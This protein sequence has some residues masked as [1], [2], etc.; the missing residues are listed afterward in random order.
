MSAYFFLVSWQITSLF[1][2]NIME[3]NLIRVSLRQ[4][5]VYVPQS[6][7]QG[8]PKQLS[9]GTSVFAANLAK[10]GYGMSEQLLHAIDQAGD[11]Y[12]QGLMAIFR[13]VM[14]VDKNWTP[15][16]K[17]WLVPTGESIIDHIVTFFA[18]I[19]QTA[20]PRLQCG[21]IIPPG[22]F[23]LERY[24]GCP[25]CGTPFEFGKIEVMGQGKKL[26]VLDRWEDADVD[27]FL[28]SL[29]LSKTA[30]DATQIDS[31]QKLLTVRPLPSVAVGMK[32]TLMV[33]IDHLIKL[34][35]AD[36]AAQYF[37][38]PTDILRYLWY[39]HTG[40]LQI[41]EPKTIVLRKK[42]NAVHLFR[43]LDAS[44]Q[45]KLDA[46]AALKLK[47]GRRDSIRVAKWLNE[48]ALPPENMAEIMHPKRNIW[49]R[50]IRALRLAEY[51]RRPGFEN[52]ATLLDI[53]YNQKY[54]VWQGKV[55]QYRLRKDMA[56]TLALLQQR[57]GLFARSLFAT[58]LWFG[59]E[60]PLQAFAEVLDKV[61][62]RLVFTL[63]M[64]AA[65]YFDPASPRIV[66]PLGGTAKT[67]AKHPLL[68]RYSKEQRAAMVEGIENLSL[69]VMKKRF[70]AIPNSNKTMYI[71]PG[72]FKMPVAI[73]DRSESVQDMPVA[74]MGT[75]FL[76]EGSAV[77]LF[78]QWGV[79]LPAMHLDMDLSAA[80]VY[81][82]RTEDCAYFNLTPTG[83][84]HSGDIQQ[85]PEKIGTAEYVELNLDVLQQAQ[86]LYAVFACNA[87]TSGALSPNMSVG[88]MTCAS[89]MHVSNE[90]GVAYDP[91]TVQHQVRIQNSLSKGLCFGMLE[92]A[93]REIVWME[94]PF[95]GQTVRGMKKE[96][97]EAMLRKLDS[98]LSVGNLLKIKA[99][100]QGLRIVESG[101]ADEIYTMAWAMNAAA[102]TQLLTD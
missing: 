7:T 33:V 58:M 69:L 97:I 17:N 1:F 31:L 72:L 92:I 63:N 101:E 35:R 48:M 3:E 45:A 22:T 85:I 57:P 50:F 6:G 67:V 88:W 2:L 36:E 16:V 62:A 64:Y 49:V 60:G 13:E 18:N 84:L 28:T 89:P 65:E 102:V 79:G 4:M 29:L 93:T 80:I 5:A 59:P 10:L 37:K 86:A 25:F 42:M 98:K 32:E 66:K 9:E 30:L 90:T 20:G 47:Y 26:K 46:K 74:L 95:G 54:E 96:A 24:N 87:Y 15:L 70:A 40:F 81:A 52:L 83:C 39:K 8:P 23:P 11:G 68:K 78:M 75:R 94:L 55:E 27:R 71:A 38:S 21:H 82:D 99:E 12:Q 91:S 61:P 34:E 41:V 73:G 100:A 77:R 44:A 56:Q 76:V 51:A 14:N 19:F 43:G 53:F